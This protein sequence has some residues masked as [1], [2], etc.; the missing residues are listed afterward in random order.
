MNQNMNDTWIIDSGASQNVSFRWEWFHQFAPCTANQK[1]ILGDDGCCEL[2]GSIEN[3]LYVPRLK[4]NLSS[5]RVCTS[6]GYNVIFH[7]QDA[8]ITSDNQ[9]IAQGKM[10]SNNIYRLLFRAQLNAKPMLL[11]VCNCYMSTGAHLNTRLKKAWLMDC[12]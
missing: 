3:V 11:L 6:Q 8:V 4:K 12:K 10:Q 7:K 9:V 2:R 5:A 1:V